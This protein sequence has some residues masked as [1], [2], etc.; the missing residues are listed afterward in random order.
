MTPRQRREARAWFEH[1]KKGG[2]K[3]WTY[4]YPETPV[5]SDHSANSAEVSRGAFSIRDSFRHDPASLRDS[6]ANP[7]REIRG[8]ECKRSD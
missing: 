8:G 1:L 4:D 6:S 7:D 3:M 2:S 5:G